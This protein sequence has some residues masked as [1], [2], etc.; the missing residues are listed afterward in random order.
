MQ[1]DDVTSS[2]ETFKTAR[3][4]ASTSHKFKRN[5]FFGFPV[6]IPASLCSPIKDAAAKAA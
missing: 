2:L 5:V 1:R 6:D 4:S 3:A